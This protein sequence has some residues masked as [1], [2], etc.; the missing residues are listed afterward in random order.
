MVFW[1]AWSVLGVIK[2]R[3][4]DT[5]ES[6]PLRHLLMFLVQINIYYNVYLRSS[7]SHIIE[8]NA[9]VGVE[10]LNALTSPTMRMMPSQMCLFSMTTAGG[11]GPVCAVR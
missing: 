11:R 8:V 1:L 4:R 7:E 3:P 5:I 9:W 6:P 2:F 10:S